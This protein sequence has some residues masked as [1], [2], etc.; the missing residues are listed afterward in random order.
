MR[1]HIDGTAGIRADANSRS[2]PHGNIVRGRLGLAIPL[3]GCSLQTSESQL[4]E[5]FFCPKKCTVSPHRSRSEHGP[6][7]ARRVG[8][9]RTS[10]STCM[11]HSHAKSFYPR[12]HNHRKMVQVAA[13]CSW[14]TPAAG[15]VPTGRTLRVCTQAPGLPRW[16]C[17]GGMPARKDLPVLVLNFT[18]IADHVASVNCPVVRYITTLLNRNDTNRLHAANVEAAKRRAD[19][20][21]VEALPASDAAD[22]TALLEQWRDLGVHFV[23]LSPT[24]PRSGGQFGCQLSFMRALKMQ[25]DQQIPYMLVMEDDVKI[26]NP[27]YLRKALCLSTQLLDKSLGVPGRRPLEL[28]S[29]GELG[30][31]FFTSLEGARSIMSDFCDVGIVQNRD[32][33]MLDRTSMLS[34][35]CV[36][37][38][39]CGAKCMRR[40]GQGHIRTLG[41]GINGTLL[42]QESRSWPRPAWCPTTRQPRPV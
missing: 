12:Y 3:T 26:F 5:R 9:Q 24:S 39:G 22:S 23:R 36:G 28:I 7:S 27:Q 32:F 16:I 31:L 30:E 14:C 1:A 6:L 33:Q 17:L 13:G 21:R 37:R 11:H 41:H 15:P 40:G 2:E 25:L 8:R 29:L 19:G 35:H 34:L 18:A 42:R 10:K 20:F 4:E 38:N